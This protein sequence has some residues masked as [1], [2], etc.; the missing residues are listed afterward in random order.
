MQAARGTPLTESGDADPV[1]A[2]AAE[3]VDIPPRR[4]VRLLLLAVLVLGADV[5]TKVAVVA[6]LSGRPPV[7]LLGGA[8]LLRETRNSGAAFSVAQG[9]TVIFTLVA[10]AVVIA[11]LRTA[12][13]LRSAPWAVSLGL[14]LGGATGNLADRMLRAP[15]PFRGH[16]VDWI[17]FRVWPVFN[18]AD[19][20][21]VIGGLLAVLLSARGRALD[22]TDRPR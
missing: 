5:L 18:L 10:A 6:H 14:L 12:S 16:V 4:V 13:R 11:I 7:R 1:Q 15:G 3:T 9:A 20:A 2:G 21:I 19:S 22:G 17:D 8:L